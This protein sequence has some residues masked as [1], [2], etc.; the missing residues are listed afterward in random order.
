MVED[1]SNGAHLIWTDLGKCE[2]R[3]RQ[4]VCSCI[5]VNNL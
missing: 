5:V 4:E 2:D 1:A 3:L